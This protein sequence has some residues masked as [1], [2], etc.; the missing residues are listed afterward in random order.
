MLQ[1]F[2]LISLIAI[3]RQILGVKLVKYNTYNQRQ[4]LCNQ[5]LTQ[6]VSD[7]KQTDSVKQ[8]KHLKVV[9][10][11]RVRRIYEQLKPLAE[12]A[13]SGLRR[14]PDQNLLQLEFPV[15]VDDPA[16]EEGDAVGHVGDVEDERTVDNQLGLP[17]HELVPIKA[18]HLVLVGL[19]Q[20]IALRPGQSFWLTVPKPRA[21]IPKP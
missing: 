2:I 11:P 1:M 20:I 16:D 13:K 21:Q 5:F 6:F 7:I 8:T 18:Q 15:G 9:K 14:C 10:A 17:Q 4:L 19:D 12:K 3:C